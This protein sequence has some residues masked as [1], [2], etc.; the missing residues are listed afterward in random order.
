MNALARRITEH[1]SFDDLI[2]GLL[3]FNAAAMGLETSAFVLD[4]Y[5]DA[6]YGFF[7]VSQVIFVAEILLRMAAADGLRS[8]FKDPWNSFDAAVVAISLL[9]AVGGL[10]YLARLVRVLR[11]VRLFSVSDTMRSWVGR[12]GDSL[13]LLARVWVALGVLLYGFGV[14]GHACFSQIDPERWGNLG[15]ALLTLVELA[16]GEGLRATVLAVVHAAPFG[17]LLFVGWYF[18]LGTLLVTALAELV[19]ARREP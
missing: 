9:P 6:F 4:A 5:G 15:L 8:F 13:G 2:L 16:F 10:A 1:E 18:S 19:A 7:V 11:M 12:L 3:V 17:V 14:A